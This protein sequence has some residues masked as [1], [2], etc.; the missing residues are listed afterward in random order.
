MTL[1]T[2][3]IKQTSAI[4]KELYPPKRTQVI[5]SGFS[6]KIEPDKPAREFSFTSDGDDVVDLIIEGTKTFDLSDPIDKHN[7]DVLNIFCALNPYSAKSLLLYNPQEAVERQITKDKQIF[8]V[9]KFLRDHEQDEIL[10]GQLYRRVVGPA[11]GLTAKQ[12]FNKLINV[13]KEDSDKFMVG[14]KIV[15]LTQDF[16]LMALL[17]IALEKGIV[18]K[19]SEGRIKKDRDTIYAKSQEDAAFQLKSDVDFKVYL[20]RGVDPKATGKQQPYEPKFE[21]SDFVKL[22]SSLGKE[23]GT[24]TLDN[25][26]L[27]DDEDTIKVNIEDFKDASLIHVEGK[28]P[29]TKYLIPT[30]TQEK[31]TKKELVAFFQK[32]QPFYDQLKESVQVK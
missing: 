20:Q 28:G 32:N 3:S 7:W 1:V 12:I 17:D 16:E 19:D 2:A 23:V 14:D 6:G 11:T 31:F 13:A 25:Q 5:S 30:I 26:G 8:E 15:S 27:G 24:K 18:F 21:D 22:A 29:Q 10:L 4:R 9:E